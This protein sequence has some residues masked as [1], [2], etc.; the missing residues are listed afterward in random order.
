M[1]D[2]IIRLVLAAFLATLEGVEEAYYRARDFC[3]VNF[4]KV[5]FGAI[6]LGVLFG[7][8][9]CAPAQR[10]FVSTYPVSLANDPRDPYAQ[11]Y[12]SRPRPVTI[13]VWLHNPLPHD[14]VAEVYC[15]GNI[16]DGHST[17][18]FNVKAYGERHFL[19][20]VMSPDMHDACEVPFFHFTNLPGPPADL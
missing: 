5:V 19:V 6:V 7:L 12:F 14:V 1:I 10:P 2:R 3:Q 20:E 8:T 18:K 11:M 15:L 9:C 16:L 4:G 17:R 13:A